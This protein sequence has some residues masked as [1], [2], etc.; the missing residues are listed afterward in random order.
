MFID[1]LTPEVFDAVVIANIAI[2]LLIAG[3][4][5]A[6]DLRRPLPDDAPDWARARLDETNSSASASRS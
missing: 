5:F 3:R 6:R 4:R 1:F 2:G